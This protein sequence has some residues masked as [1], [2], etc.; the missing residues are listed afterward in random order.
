MTDE[1]IASRLFSKVLVMEFRA[2]NYELRGYPLL[3]AKTFHRAAL[4]MREAMQI[5]PES[6]SYPSVYNSLLSM[7]VSNYSEAAKRA[8]VQD[9]ATF[10]RL[11]ECWLLL[12][13]VKDAKHMASIARQLYAKI[14]KSPQYAHEVGIYR[15]LHS[16]EK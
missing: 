10:A 15:L 11:A 9:P 14:E 4:E 3:A 7:A 5:H 1:K 8:S 2:R 12:G 6:L 13:E 16:S